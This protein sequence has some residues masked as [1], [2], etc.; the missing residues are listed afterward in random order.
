MSR[1]INCR[2]SKS[3]VNEVHFCTCPYSEFVNEDLV[4]DEKCDKC[5]DFF[6]QVEDEN[7]SIENDT[8]EMFYE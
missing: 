2:W 6:S 5:T 4:D 8:E 3:D 1:F 7:I